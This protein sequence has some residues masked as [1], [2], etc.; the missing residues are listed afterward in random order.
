MNPTLLL[1]AVIVLSFPQMIYAQ[2][3][4]CTGSLGDN[5]FTS[6]DFG[7]GPANIV[8]TN[9]GFAPGYTYGTVGPPPD[10][11]YVITNST[12]VWPGLYPSWMR[13]EDNSPDPQG[14]MMVVN[15]DFNPG[16]FYEQTVSNLCENTLYEFSADMI[17]IVLRGVADHIRP[18]VSFLLNGQEFLSTGEIPQD[19]AWHNYGFT[20]ETAPGQTEITLALRNN[21]PGGIGNDLALDNITFRACGPETELVPDGLVRTCADLA[22][23]LTV[24]VLNSP[25]DQTRWQWELSTDSGMTWQ[26]I[27][28]AT[29]E[30]YVHGVPQVGSYWYRVLLA[31]GPINLSNNKCRVSSPIT[32]VQ[33]EP[34]RYERQDSICEG[35]MYQVGNSVYTASGTYV[36]SLRTSTGCDSIIETQLTVLPRA[37]IVPDMLIEGTSCHDRLDGQ[38]EIANISGGFPPYQIQFGVFDEQGVGATFSNLRGGDYKLFLTD[39]YGCT[40]QQLVTVPRPDSFQVDLGPDIEVDLGE[41]VDLALM[42]NLEVSQTSWQG[43]EPLDCPNN[44]TELTLLP[45][46]SGALEVLATSL[47]G[48]QARDTV[49]IDLNRTDRDLYFPSA[50]SPN[51]D[52]INERFSVYGA[53]PLVQTYDLQVFNRWG[54]RIFVGQNLTPNQSDDGWDGRSEGELLD[55][56]VYVY[57]VD[58]RFLDGLV[59]RYGG[60]ITLL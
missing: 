19:E 51:G 40:A 46:Q 9:P 54:N 59:R 7:S 21:A 2:G 38:V 42:S 1:V 17:N 11:L 48:C 43:F 27:A 57:V 3:P 28:G 25:Y 52:G 53:T 12:S 24:A 44:C 16:L 26:A 30:T 29:T 31:N 10:G 32:I 55:Q 41:Y 50:F 39:R 6:G 13:L 35:N 23:P 15:A 22:Q 33:V 56:G 5:I 45:T 58:V 4:V 14:Y 36:D 60:S 34:E 8:P 47:R 18:N 20:F 37:M 49:Q